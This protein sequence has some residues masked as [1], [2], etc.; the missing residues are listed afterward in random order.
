MVGGEDGGERYGIFVIYIYIYYQTCDFSM[1]TRSYEVHHVGMPEVRIDQNLSFKCSH[2][3]L[4][5]F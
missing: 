4:G 3:V 1:P 5:D 2:V